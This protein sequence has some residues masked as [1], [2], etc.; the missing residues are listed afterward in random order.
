MR[1][2]DREITGRQGIEEI[3]CGCKTCR[4]AM[5]D[6]G[7]PYIVPMSFG[8]K[9][10]DDGAIELYFHSAKE[11]KKLD[12]LKV[13]SKVGFEISNEGEAISAEVPCNLGYYYFSI[14]GF[15]EASFIDDIEEKCAALSSIVKHQAAK[16]ME[17]TGEQAEAV[18]V[19]KIASAEY[20][21]KRKQKP[22][23][24]L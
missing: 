11:G 17:I 22:M 3:L 16:D 10:F 4:I 21:G 23:G 1:R 9:Y 15:G 8:Y 5:I 20:T 12:I 7:R 13:N 24:A 2:N 18:C 14:I 6:E 19:F